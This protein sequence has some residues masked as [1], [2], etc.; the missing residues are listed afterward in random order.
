VVIV[1]VGVLAVTVGAFVTAIV[2]RWPQVDPSAPRLTP[3]AVEREVRA[4]PGARAYVRARLDPGTVTGLALTAAVAVV[5]AG[6]V[7]AGLLFAMVRTQTGLAGYD[8]GAA[9]WGAQHAT[10]ASTWTLR[11]LTQLGGTEGVILI[12]V[13][14]LVAEW[15]RLGP[16]IPLAFLTLVLVGETVI[17]NL[18]K[19]VVDRARPDIDR[20]VGFS[21]ASF[22]SGHAAT[23]AAMWAAFA[24]LLGRRRSIT[25]KAVL[26]GVAAGVAVAVAA[27]RV[28]LGVH[29]FTDVLAGLAL[30]WA[31]FAACSIAF[32]GRLLHFGAPVELAER[33]ADGHEAEG[34]ASS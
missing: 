3:Q 1:I 22:P 27:S 6:A 25:T 30:G 21:G 31:W 15:R 29:W 18:T 33:V 20:L 2:R 34:R 17:T 7:A 5:A 8:L 12:G 9:R 16:A 14:V 23:A 4:H 13:V 19:W 28:L 10:A 32:G 24:L 11:A 26:A